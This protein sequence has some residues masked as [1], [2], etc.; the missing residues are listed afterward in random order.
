M[1][2]G[3]T[4]AA[5]LIG[6][7]NYQEDRVIHILF[8][9]MFGNR[10]HLIGILDGHGGDEV[11]NYCAKHITNLFNP[12]AKNSATELERLIRALDVRTQFMDSGSTLSLAWIDERSSR[13]TTAI[14]GDSPVV[15]FDS[16]GKIHIGVE[17]N[18]RSNLAERARTE[19]RGGVYGYD[20][21]IFNKPDGSGHTGN[22][23]QLSRALGDTELRKVLDQTPEIQ[24]FDIGRDSIVIVASDG[25]FDPAHEAVDSS[26]VEDLIHWATKRGCNAKG[27]L[28]L[29][30]ARLGEY[31]DNA[32]IIFWRPITRHSWL[33]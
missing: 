27:L 17:H 25:V 26:F 6:G 12:N 28:D 23:L 5:Q 11:A 21:Y 15:V 1:L 8:S 31:G 18:V 14:L 22:G 33:R 7:R 10:G 20:G 2:K 9:N 13:V 16:E 30:R 3:V 4:D 32:S 29:R 24:Q 19:S